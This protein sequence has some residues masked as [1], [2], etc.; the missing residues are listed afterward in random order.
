MIP[1]N[2]PYRVALV[3]CGTVGSAVAKLIGRRHGTSRARV[4]VE[5]AYIVDKDFSRAEEA[6]L[7]S[8]LFESN[9]Q[10]VLED[11]SIK[12]IIE[13]IGGI[14]TARET[15]LWA[16]DA[17]K[18]VVTA[19]KALLAHHGSELHAA[20]RKRGVCICFEA[21]CGSG[22]PIIRALTEGLIANR[23]AA[24]YGILNGTCNY[25]L[26]AMSKELKSYAEALGEAQKAG[27]AE[28]DPALDV[29]GLDTAHKLTILSSLAFGKRVDLA[30][31][32]VEGIDTLMAKDLAYGQELGYVAKLLAIAEQ[33]DRGL[34]LN[35]RPAFISKEHPLAWVAGP[36]NAVS[37]YGDATG[38]TLYYGRGAGG[39]PTA[40]AVVADLFSLAEGTAQRVYEIFDG[41]DRAER[42]DQLPLDEIE[43]RYYIR[44]DVED[45]PGVLAQIASC[46]GSHR[47]SISSVLQKEVLRTEGI[48]HPAPAA[49]A[50]ADSRSAKGTSPG[51]PAA[52]GPAAG[53][54]VVITTHR[55]REG[56]VRKALQEIDG[57]DVVKSRGVCIEMMDERQEHL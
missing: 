1:S 16:V 6:N 5:L 4:A 34:H 17:G 9:Y 44:I 35:V 25:I 12:A 38:H 51:V 43:S 11:E 32:P 57:M 37:I 10:T 27:F 49:G 39:A 50:P 3:G 33:T 13:L 42:A 8:T 20:A 52:G 41:P 55:A 21:S 26:T 28:A 53:V 24:F 19:N 47:I 40:S 46:L 23:I 15:I 31:I 36:F 14:T 54:P 30:A 56:S 2:D 7:D 48:S 29:S 18:H 22:I 45:K